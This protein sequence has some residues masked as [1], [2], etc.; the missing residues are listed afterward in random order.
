VRKR[1]L[2]STSTAVAIAGGCT[3]R[4]TGPWSSSGIGSLGWATRPSQVALRAFMEITAAN[5]LDVVRNNP[6]IAAKHGHALQRLFLRA[7][8][9]LP[10]PALDAWVAQ[11]AAALSL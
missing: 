11:S 10:P 7:S 9:H 1:K 6:D 4:S 3:R 2:S 8:E 5:E